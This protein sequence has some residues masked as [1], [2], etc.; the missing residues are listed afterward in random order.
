MSQS[1]FEIKCVQAHFILEN[2]QHIFTQY[3]RL[4]SEEVLK[5]NGAAILA[6]EKQI[7]KK[8]TII[9][10]ADLCPLCG[11]NYGLDSKR[12]VLKSRKVPYCWMCGQRLDW[13]TNEENS[14]ETD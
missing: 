8:I 10:G 14:S 12:K 2:F 6:L 13:N 11:F 3:R 9:N 1:D 7:P 5:A 4:M